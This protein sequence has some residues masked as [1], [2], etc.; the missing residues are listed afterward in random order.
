MIPWS[1]V[2]LFY[3]CRQIQYKMSQNPGLSLN[4]CKYL[5]FSP[6][7]RVELFPKEIY[8][9]QVHCYLND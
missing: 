8:E 3:S 7:K 4:I 6:I 5:R 1:V 2:S 9:Y